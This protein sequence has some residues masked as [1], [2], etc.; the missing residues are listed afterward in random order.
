MNKKIVPDNFIVPRSLETDRMRLRFLSVNDV[1]KD[2]DAVMSSLNYL[3]RTQPFGPEHKWPT[4]ELTLEQDLID[5]GWHQKE[6]Q[7]KSSFAY[8]VMSLDEKICLGCLYIYPS[9]KSM[10]DVM[11]MMWVRESEA[12]SGLDD[13]LFETVKKWFVEKWPFGKVAYPGREITWEAWHKIN[14]HI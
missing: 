10:Y 13:H 12:L 6:F 14:N 5:L 9:E 2:Y 3:Q 1:I 11:V 8:T 7:K 4:K